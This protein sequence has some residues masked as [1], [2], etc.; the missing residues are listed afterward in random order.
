MG[1]CFIVQ[2]LQL[3]PSLPGP[4]S[5]HSSQ[6]TSR[7]KVYVRI[8]ALALFTIHT[9]KDIIIQ[10]TSHCLPVNQAQGHAPMPLPL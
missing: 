4:R 7:A 5:I 9:P 10:P 1:H 2:P 8:H 3:A 6:I